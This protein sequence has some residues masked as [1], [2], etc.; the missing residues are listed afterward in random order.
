[1]NNKAKL[2]QYTCYVGVLPEGYYF[3]GKK[4][5]PKEET[6]PTENSK[7]IG[8]ATPVICMPD[9]TIQPFN[10]LNDYYLNDK[11]IDRDVL[12]E[13]GLQVENG[14]VTNRKYKQGGFAMPWKL[15]ICKPK[16]VSYDV[17][18]LN[19]LFYV[20]DDRDKITSYKP[21]LFKTMFNNKGFEK[22]LED[23]GTISVVPE[24]LFEIRKS[25]KAD[26]AD[27]V[28]YKLNN[29]YEK[30]FYKV[31]LEKLPE[32]ERK[33]ENT[34][35][36]NNFEIHKSKTFTLKE[37]D[38]TVVETDNEKELMAYAVPI[39]GYFANS[40]L[41][42]FLQQPI[43]NEEY[44]C[45]YDY[46]TDDYIE[47]NAF[48]RK[49]D[50]ANLN[51]SDYALNLSFSHYLEA[52]KIHEILQKSKPFKNMYLFR[53][54]SLKDDRYKRIKEGYVLS[55]DGFKSTSFSSD[56]STM[57]LPTSENHRGIL[58][59]IDCKNTTNCLY[60]HNLADTQE[61]ETLIDINYDLK[62]VKELGTFDGVPVWLTE[63]V[64][65]PSKIDNYLYQPD[66]LEK[67]LNVL[68]SDN[69]IKKLF[70]IALVDDDEDES[71]ILLNQIF[72][73]ENTV[74]ITVTDKEVTVGDQKI[75]FDDVYFD[76]DLLQV[77]YAQKKES[78][79]D[80]IDVW[81][82][83]QRISQNLVSLLLANNI[84]IQNQE[85][86][87]DKTHLQI[88]V[89]D[90]TS[91]NDLSTLTVEFNYRVDKKDIY[92]SFECN[93]NGDLKKSTETKITH[94]NI[95]LMAQAVYNFLMHNYILN[96]ERRLKHIVKLVGG[97]YM[98]ESK[99]ERYNNGYKAEIGDK[100]LFITK[101]G[102]S[103]K[104]NNLTFN[105]ADNI[106]DIATAIKEE[107]N[108]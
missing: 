44:T 5:V 14:R 107:L 87:R 68:Q 62:F 57:F 50:K 21:S 89:D 94:K 79:P 96:C 56:V 16:N 83:N 73:E 42:N 23:V 55:D 60:I 58:C 74:R 54:L 90:Y 93:L 71:K 67:V 4:A 59:L 37:S 47:I 103:L 20:R 34:V 39:L 35:Q 106:Y 22:E 49:K 85:V 30:S 100:L 97:Y 43:T 53:G 46:T 13:N 27:R 28:M 40:T 33:D 82:I 77:V 81:Q 80:E 61:Y 2:K 36:V 70:Y 32:I 25:S 11:E 12:L 18:Y 95:D 63:T 6:K 78:E 41:N 29:L 24:P 3:N 17:K 38:E 98:S 51:S 52:V 9:G 19:N 86:N 26:F 31:T 108:M 45:L 104:A 88:Y 72:N 15:V 48:L 7:Y 64:R 10:M 101:S 92:L 105:Y 65:N 8:K 76:F 91:E 75:A 66:A 69:K 1:M 84:V 99:I 102:N